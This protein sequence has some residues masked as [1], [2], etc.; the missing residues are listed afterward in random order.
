MKIPDECYKC[1]TEVNVK[2]D[3]HVMI[4]AFEKE[5]NREKFDTFILCVSCYEGFK[6]E[7]KKKS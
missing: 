1:K 3:K 5:G 4:D 7:H 2:M 6:G